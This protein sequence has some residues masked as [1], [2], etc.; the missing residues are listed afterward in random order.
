M[1]LASAYAHELPRYGLEVGLTNYAA[2]YCTGLLLACRVL[3]ILEMEDEYEGNVEG[4]LDGG[5]D[6]PHSDK[7]FSGFSKDSKQLDAE[8]HR[9]HIYG[10]H[11]AAYMKILMEDEPEKYQSHFVEYIK[12]GIEPDGI[13]ELHKK[14]HAAIRRDPTQMKSEKEPHKQH[15]RGTT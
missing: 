1:V 11:V 5:L 7:R 8:V 15:K 6:I 10:G 13:E 9:K 14:V 2:A 12:R 4:A 3:K